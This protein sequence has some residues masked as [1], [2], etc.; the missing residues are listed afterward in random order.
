MSA[1][2]EIMTRAE[3]CIADGDRDAESIIRECFDLEV[4]DDFRWSLLKAV[5]NASDLGE[6]EVLI[7]YCIKELKDEVQDLIDDAEDEEEDEE[8][9]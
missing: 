3:C 4:Y 7:D 1:L 5:Y 9:W 8:E 6:D 2:D